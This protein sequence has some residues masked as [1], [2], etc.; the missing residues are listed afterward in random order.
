MFI[1]SDVLIIQ[2]KIRGDET[3]FAV[4]IKLFFVLIMFYCSYYFSFHVNVTIKRF[5]LDIP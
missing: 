4:N 3:D 1:I 2:L 5:Y